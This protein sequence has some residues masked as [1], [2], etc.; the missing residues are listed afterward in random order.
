[1]NSTP[2]KKKQEKIK[3][4]NK[5]QTNKQQQQKKPQQQLAVKSNKNIKKVR[6]IYY[7]AI[8]LGKKIRIISI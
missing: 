6:W 2:W 3:Q 1:M 8:A 7:N 4:N 5:K